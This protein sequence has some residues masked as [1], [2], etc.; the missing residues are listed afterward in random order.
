VKHRQLAITATIAFAIVVLVVG[1]ASVD[2]DLE[3]QVFTS[4]TEHLRIV[5][6]R[7]WRATDQPSYPGL[8]LWM[9]RSQP[10]GRIVLTSEPFTRELYCSWPLDCRKSRESLPA[11]MACALRD[12]LQRQGMHVDATQAGP[13]ENEEAGLPSVWI[14]YD[15]G[16]HF[17]R[18]AIAFDRERSIASLVLSAPTRAGRTAH[19][20]AFEQALRTM[21]ST[22]GEPSSTTASAPPDAGVAPELGSAAVDSPARREPIGP[23]PP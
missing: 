7:G 5:V 13:K 19:V 11:R 16:K 15:D 10:E 8:L 17:L 9:M 2:A 21:R 23:C 20:R 3:N 18:Q 1:V 12:R 14:E 22:A 6:P 4:K